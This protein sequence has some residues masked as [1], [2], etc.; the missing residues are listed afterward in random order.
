MSDI[1]PYPWKKKC[2]V[3]KTLFRKEKKR[4]KENNHKKK[5]KTSDRMRQKQNK[6]K[7][8]ERHEN[9]EKNDCCT[10]NKNLTDEKTYEQVFLPWDPSL[11]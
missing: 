6:K 3:Y 8:H 1:T 5:Y 4:M 2:F 10:H 7:N 9:K 11:I